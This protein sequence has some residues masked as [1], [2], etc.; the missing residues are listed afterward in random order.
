MRKSI[1]ISVLVCIAVIGIIAFVLTQ[2]K[3]K[4]ATEPKITKPQAAQSETVKQSQTVN[5]KTTP[6]KPKPIEIPPKSITEITQERVETLPPDNI[7]KTIQAQTAENTLNVFKGKNYH[8]IMNEVRGLGKDLSGE[9]VAELMEF[10]NSK[11]NGQNGLDLLAFNAIKND[12]LEKLIDQKN[13]PEG[14]GQ[15]MVDMYRDRSLD[16]VWRDYCVQHFPRYLEAKYPEGISSDNSEAKA[17]RYALWDAVNETESSIA[18]TALI[19]LEKISKMD[20]QCDRQKIANQAFAYAR[21]DG[22][23]VPAR[24]TAMQLCGVMGQPQIL[25]TAKSVATAASSIPLRMSAIATIGDVGGQGDI[26]FL[27]NIVKS[28]DSYYIKNSAQ[29][30]LKRLKK[31]LGIKE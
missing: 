11:F 28:S 9:R 12:L 19:A 14:L 2:K 5:D 31:R 4:P 24:I 21:D 20:P 18:G 30:A 8:D 27:E 25:P 23:P 17:M 3:A 7:N 26:G 15:Y 1:N 16:V 10:L 29:S 13:I 22:C 6:I